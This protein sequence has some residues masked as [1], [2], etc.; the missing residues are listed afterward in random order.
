MNKH[1]FHSLIKQLKYEVFFVS[2]VEEPHYDA[3]NKLETVEFS[4]KGQ[5]CELTLNGS[6]KLKT[7]QNNQDIESYQALLQGLM[8]STG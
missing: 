7:Q 5:H 6:I 8:R 1:L 4:Y 2:D 3:S